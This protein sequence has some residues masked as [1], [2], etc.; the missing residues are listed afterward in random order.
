[1][2]VSPLPLLVA[3]VVA[4]HEHYAPAADHLALIT[5]T[6]N[7]GSDFHRAPLAVVTPAKGGR[8]E[9]GHRNSGETLEYTG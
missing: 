9:N 3:W 6:L 1:M 8:V 5:N 2:V 4:N 7:A